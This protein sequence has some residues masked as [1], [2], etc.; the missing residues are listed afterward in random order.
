MVVI[1]G[2]WRLVVGLGQEPGL[3]SFRGQLAIGGRCFE[4][5][6]WWLFGP[7]AAEK[8]FKKIFFCRADPNFALQN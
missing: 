8:Y 6:G 4:V 3:T 2:G 1:V 5:G 7:G